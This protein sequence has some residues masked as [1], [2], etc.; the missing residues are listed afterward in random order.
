MTTGT[1]PDNVTPQETNTTTMSEE[2]PS[3]EQ[4]DEIPNENQDAWCTNK[5]PFNEEEEK[6]FERLVTLMGSIAGNEIPPMRNMDK[7]HLSRASAKV[8]ARFKKITLKK[9]NTINKVMNCGGIITSELLGVTNRKN[10]QKNYPMW[11]K[12]LENQIKDLCKDP[13]RVIELSKGN[14]LKRKHS[15]QLQKKYFLNQKG[16]VYVIPEV[17]Q[18][19]KSK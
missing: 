19:I 13:D 14:K 8:N 1:D 2:E 10:K 18:R 15:D 5:K 17:R 11:K 7:K 6:I 4:I 12:R 3:I 9:I 16:F